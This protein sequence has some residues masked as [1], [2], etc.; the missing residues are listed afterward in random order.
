[1]A[2]QYLSANFVPSQPKYPMQ[3]QPLTAQE[4]SSNEQEA[5][6]WPQGWGGVYSSAYPASGPLTIAY[7]CANS[8]GI[9]LDMTVLDPS[10][11]SIP[12]M[13]ACWMVTGM[14]VIIGDTAYSVADGFGLINFNFHTYGSQPAVPFMAALT[15]P[16]NANSNG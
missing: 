5:A 13:P 11:V 1:M 10:H 4:I 8:G 6:G 7:A 16:M 15:A 2:M 3:G 14:P 12:P 9:A